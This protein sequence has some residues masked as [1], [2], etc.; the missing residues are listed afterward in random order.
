[1][2]FIPWFASLCVR[3]LHITDMNF[4]ASEEAEE[5]KNGFGS[6]QPFE[7]A[8]F[9]ELGFSFLGLGLP[10]PQGLDFPSPGLDFSSLAACRT[11]GA[12]ER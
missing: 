10:F 8:Q 11:R 5:R 4:N 2:S 1:M 3:R 12:D 9:A 6:A 7:N